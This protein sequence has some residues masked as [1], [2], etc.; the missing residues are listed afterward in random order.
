M[1]PNRPAIHEAIS[2]LI[3]L[4][5]AFRRR[6]GQLARGAGI[7]EH[8]WAVLEEIST[9]H[10]M[11]S[12]FA[13]ENSS[14]PAAVSKVIRQLVEKGLVKV[15][16][17][18]SDG[19]QRSY[20]LTAHGRRAMAELREARQSAIANVWLALDHRDVSEFVRVGRELTARLEQYAQETDKE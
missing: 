13:R 20:G 8:Q 6:R 19:R 4:T 11:P 5:E 9:E 16:L 10:F 17:S 14:S 2:T 18:K 7:T 3:R 12:M 1:R 15:S